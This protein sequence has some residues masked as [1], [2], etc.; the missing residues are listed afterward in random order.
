MLRNAECMQNPPRWSAYPPTN[1]TIR[2]LTILTIRVSL[3]AGE[4]LPR[5]QSDELRCEF[6]RATEHR[7]ARKSTRP[8]G[9]VQNELAPVRREPVQ[10]TVV[11]SPD[12]RERCAELLL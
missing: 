11:V 3:E 12:S 1:P 4:A 2:P 5:L 7:V 9:D 8:P 10:R 6:V